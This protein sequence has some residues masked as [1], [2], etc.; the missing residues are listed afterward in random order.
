MYCSGLCKQHAAER[1]RQVKSAAEEPRTC[2]KCGVGKAT[3]RVGTAVCGKCKVEKHRGSRFD[4]ERRRTLRK[5][6]LTQDGWDYL[7]AAQGNRCAIC[8]TDKPGSKGEWWHID[9]CH[10][11]NQVRGL[12]CHMCNVGVGNLKDDP[13][14]LRAAAEYIEA[15]RVRSAA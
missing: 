11:T 13:A 2:T 10:T 14:L 5:Y 8:Q 6:G 15:A 1:R 12:L 4:Y 7:L 9:H 3:A